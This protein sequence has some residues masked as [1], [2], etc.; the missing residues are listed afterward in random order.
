MLRYR[1]R[2]NYH[3]KFSQDEIISIKIPKIV[4]R[5]AENLLI[6]KVNFLINAPI[7]KNGKPV[8]M[9]FLDKISGISVE[10]I[11]VE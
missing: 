3:L 9:E 10:K 8:N 6:L 2:Q 4:M 7:K 11:K 5:K 1:Y